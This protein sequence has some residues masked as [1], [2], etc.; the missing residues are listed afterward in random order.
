[1]NL[2]HPNVRY[3]KM[4]DIPISFLKENNIKGVILDVDN[5]MTTHDNM[6]LAPGVE[7][8]INEARNNDIKLIILSN[9]SPQRVRP[10]AEEFALEFEAKARKPLRRGYLRACRKMGLGP[11]EVAAIGDQIFTDVIGARLAGIYCI[12]VDYFELE[13]GSFFKFKRALERPI[14]AGFERKKKS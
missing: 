2:L 13:H 12:F 9:N 14:L 3:K 10:L 5:T 11:Q 6:K 7:D 8:W 1:M 4:S